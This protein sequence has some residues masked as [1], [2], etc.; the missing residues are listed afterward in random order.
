MFKLNLVSFHYGKMFSWV[1]D[2]RVSVQIVGKTQCIIN[3]L[4]VFAV[5]INREIHPPFGKKLIEA[6]IS[7][8]YQG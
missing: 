8:S 3:L 5:L 2:F 7:S 4:E 6:K 1:Y